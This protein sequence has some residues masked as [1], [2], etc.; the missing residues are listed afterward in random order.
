MAKK[1]CITKNTQKYDEEVSL[2]NLYYDTNNLELYGEDDK[3]YI[4]G[5]DSSIEEMGLLNPPIVYD[6]NEIKSGHTRVRRLIA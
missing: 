4:E 3:Q 5:L 2:S 6:T 1:T